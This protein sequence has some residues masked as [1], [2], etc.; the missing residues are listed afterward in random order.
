MRV[1]ILGARGSVCVY[2][3]AALFQT[4]CPLACSPWEP[5]QG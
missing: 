1:G 5:Q 3:R 2:L 4:S